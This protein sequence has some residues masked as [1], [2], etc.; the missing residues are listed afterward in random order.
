MKW[1]SAHNLFHSFDE[2]EKMKKETRGHLT[3]SLMSATNDLSNTQN[4][5]HGLTSMKNW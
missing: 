4:I 1:K 5:F 3:W 2:Y